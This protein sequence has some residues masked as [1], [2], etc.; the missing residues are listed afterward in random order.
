MD[1]MSRRYATETPKVSSLTS[2]VKDG[3]GVVVFNQPGKVNSMNKDLLTD[4]QKIFGELQGNQ[5]CKAIVIRSGKTDCFIAG[6]DINMFK[7][8]ETDKEMEKLSLEGQ[9]VMDM[10][11]A[12]PKPVVSAIM[13]SCLGGGLELALA[14]HYRIAAVT[15]KTQLGTPEVQLGLLPGAGGTQRLLRTLPLSSA[16]DL[17]L[18]GN[19]WRADK[20]KK[21]GLVDEVVPQLG[22]GVLP[23]DEATLQHLEEVAITTAK[24]LA[25]GRL[26][27]MEKKKSLTDKAIDFLLKYEMGRSFFFGKVKA[28]VMKQTKGVYPAPLKIIQ[29]VEK[30]V[31]QGPAAG[32]ALEAEAFGVLGATTQSKGLIGLFDGMTVCKK[33]KYG[34]PEK[35]VKNLAV[36]GAGLMGAGIAQVSIEKNINT[37]LKD[38]SV[39]SLGK[40]QQ[41]IE[42]A[43]SLAVK[44]KKFSQ[45]EAHQVY[46]KLDATTSYD[47]FKNVDMVIEA[48]FEDINIKHKVIKE[49]EKYAPP[50]CVIAT[51]TSALSITKVAEASKHPENIVG[52]HYFSPVD[53]MLL[54]E[55][56]T[57]PTTSKQA[58]SSAVDVGLRQ[59]KVVIVVKDSPGFYTTRALMAIMSEAFELLLEG[60]DPKELDRVTM[61]MG[62]PVGSATLLDEVGV[63]VAAH[64]NTYLSKAI[65][66]QLSIK[67]DEGKIFDEMTAKGFLGRKSGKGVFNYEGKS[68]DR[69]VNQGFLDLLKPHMKT[70]RTDFD[71][72][73]TRLRILSRFTNQCVMCLQ[74]GILESPLEGD[75]GAVFG[76]GFPPFLGG[77]FRF[78]DI[79]GAKK[80]V[81]GMKRLQETHGDKFK[82]CDLLE[83]HSKDP[84]KKFH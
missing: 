8:L 84:S 10:I 22:P 54:L 31:V 27:R 76:L 72:E 5:D 25:S 51:N 24:N 63:D 74:E 18:T 59:G 66:T 9:K 19:P 82:P 21:A 28:K 55:I 35:P 62:F 50:H 58:I 45:S 79:Y 65:G 41:Q 17:M 71:F 7:V 42:K 39:E 56:I 2:S 53:K 49:I 73:D 44:K 20:A 40:G 57:H 48:V 30:S 61:Q 32:Y 64:I 29:V 52:M 43:L 67:P 6:A 11:E 70:I 69:V 33:N 37:V 68:K 16:L 38:I 77:P 15:K 36:L 81:D 34:A 3:V 1:I 46:S 14:T 4:F 47:G 26:K 78:V 83:S 80:L 23:A 60:M 12:S 75:I 13:G